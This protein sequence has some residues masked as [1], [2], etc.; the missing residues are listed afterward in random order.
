MISIEFIDFVTFMTRS[1][2]NMTLYMEKYINENATSFAR[3]C[4]VYMKKSVALLMIVII[5]VLDGYVKIIVLFC[6]L[7]L[8]HRK[9]LDV[10]NGR[11]VLRLLG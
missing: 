7:N 5:N 3:S 8:R 10:K 11:F 6:C 9:W 1:K 2:A 4:V